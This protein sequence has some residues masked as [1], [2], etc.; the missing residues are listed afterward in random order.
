MI[1]ALLVT[2]LLVAALTGACVAA[3]ALTDELVITV[4][5]PDRHDGGAS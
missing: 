1:T 2:A 5:R 4:K 3:I